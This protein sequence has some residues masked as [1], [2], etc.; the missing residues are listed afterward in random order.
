ML[1]ISVLLTTCRHLK[2]K[3]YAAFNYLMIKDKR[4][5]KRMEGNESPKKSPQLD[6]GQHSLAYIPSTTKN[7]LRI[8]NRK[9][10]KEVICVNGTTCFVLPPS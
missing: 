6:P 3:N 1:H 5:K 8:R 9:E 7:C 4:I 2:L 10:L